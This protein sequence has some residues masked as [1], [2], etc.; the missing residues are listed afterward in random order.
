MTTNRHRA[1]HSLEVG[2]CLN[3]DLFDNIQGRLLKVSV[4]NNFD[5]VR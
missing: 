5:P 2:M 1:E 3:G 4:A